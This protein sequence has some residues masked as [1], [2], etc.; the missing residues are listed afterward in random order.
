M[1][2]IFSLTVLA[3]TLLAQEN[4][5]IEV[6]G[7]DVRAV[8]LN[9]SLYRSE[10]LPLVISVPA[11]SYDIHIYGQKRVDYPAADY[12]ESLNIASGER[13]VF[14]VSGRL[15]MVQSIPY[16]ASVWI[17]D[18]LAGSTPLWLTFDR[19]SERA[20]LLRMPGYEDTRV[21]VTDTA[22]LN[23]YLSVRLTPTGGYREP[24]NEYLSDAWKNRGVGR[25]RGWL[26]LSGVAAVVTGGIAAYY[27]IKADDLFEKAKL[28]HRRNDFTAEASL[29]KKT[30][31]YDR[32]ATAGFIGMQ[33]SFGG[34]VF[35]FLK[36]E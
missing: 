2:W 18:S 20:L 36:S 35:L 24:D 21:I 9:D 30:K 6:R 32:Y 25:H 16:G 26:I 29:R 22:A 34:A 5:I 10:R 15:G 4:A 7:T 17:E 12:S 3:A 23:H 8:R 14:D 33:I 19:L 11:G 31:R 27:K 13:R 28:A 1:R